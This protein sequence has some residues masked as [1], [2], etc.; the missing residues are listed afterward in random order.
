MPEADT[1]ETTTNEDNA[2]A[3]FLANARFGLN[4]WWR[5]V[6]ALI[7]IH[8]IWNDILYIPYWVGCEYLNHVKIPQFSCDTGYIIGDSPIPDFILDNLHIIAIIG[9]AIT[10]KLIQKKKLTQVVTGRVT[11]DY[12]RVFYAAWTGLLIFVVFAGLEHLFVGIDVTFQAPNPAE[13]VTFLLVAVVLVPWQSG[14]EEVLFRGYLFQGVTFLTKNRFVL[15][16]IPSLA[17]TAV[18]LGHLSLEPPFITANENASSAGYVMGMFIWSAF[19]G[20]VAMFDGGIELAVGFHTINNLWIYLIINSEVTAFSGPSLFVLSSEIPES[21]F[22][23]I[24]LI[25]SYIALFVI[26]NRKYGWFSWTKFART[27]R[28]PEISRFE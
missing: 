2:A 7:F 21:Y 10:I 28:Q 9:F 8:V 12:G 15:V 27:L 16:A 23:L 20:L 25:V 13:Y 11:F 4:H 18:H 26:F 24:F 19:V 22:P 1:S 14:F 3:V 17:F 5:W 6:L